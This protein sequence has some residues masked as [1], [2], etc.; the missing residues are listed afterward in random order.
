MKSIIYQ[1]DG[2]DSVCQQ[3]LLTQMNRS[4]CLGLGKLCFH[5]MDTQ[6]KKKKKKLHMKPF[7]Q[8]GK[9]TPHLTAMPLDFLKGT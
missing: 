5:L 6:K 3:L 2:K 1:Q 8:E 9:I 7:S 4:F